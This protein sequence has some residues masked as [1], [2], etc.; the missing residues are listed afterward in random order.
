MTDTDANRRPLKSRGT[1]WASGIARLLT[2]AGLKPNQISVAS[3]FMSAGAGA[4]LIATLFVTPNWLIAMFY[5]L[6]GVF[7]QLRLLCNLFDGMVAVEG[8]LKSKSGEIFNELPDRIS[9]SI[10]LICAGYSISVL[11]GYGALLGFLAAL[12]AIFTAYI[13][14][15][16]AA[17]GTEQCFFGPMAKPHRMALIT[18]TCL[19][20]IPELFYW[21]RGIAM[22]SALL[23]LCVGCVITLARRTLRVIRQLEAQ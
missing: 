10:I 14:A 6:A 1:K 21:T 5:L 16:G 2:R 7:I 22:L 23:L 12:L 3:I 20:S 13:R 15:L 9:D 11:T 4:C 8:G 18:I 17:A 19:V